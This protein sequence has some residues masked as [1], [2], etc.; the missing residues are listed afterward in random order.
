[1]ENYQVGVFALT[2]TNET[3][4]A[5]VTTRSGSRWT[6]PKGCVEAGR[7]DRQVAEEEAYEEA[8]LIGE[9]QSTYQEFG[10]NF[11]SSDKL[12]LYRM[13]IREILDQWPERDE[14]ERVLVPIKRAEEL[15][16]ADLRACLRQM[17]A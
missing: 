7:C 14:R 15:L 6:F 11:G 4:V 9:V 10:I 12:R 5:L 13:C 2:N 17:L 8:G 3:K 16:E 1:M